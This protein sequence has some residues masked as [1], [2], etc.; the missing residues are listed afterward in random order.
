MMETSRWLLRIPARGQE[1]GGIP[2]VSMELEQQAAITPELLTACKERFAQSPQQR[3]L[4]SAVRKNGISAVAMDLERAQTMQHTFSHVIKGGPVTNQKQSGRCWM[5]AG[6]NVLRIPVMARCNLEEFELS[7][8]Y[9]MFWDK[10]EKANYFLENILETLEEPLDGRLLAWLL[11]APLGDGGQWDMFVN[12]VEKYGVVPKWV[13]PESFHSGQSRAMNALLTAKLRQ[14]AA[15]LR[16]LHAQGEGPSSLRREKERVLGEF[17]GALATFLGEPPQRFDFEYRSRDDEFHREQGLTPVEFFHRYVGMDLR[18]YISVINAPTADK[19]Y[20]RTFTVKYLGNVKGGRDVLYLNADSNVLREAAMA[21]LMDG[22]PVWFGCDVGNMQDRESVI[23]SENLFNYAAVLGVPMQMT[24]AQRLDY[25]E[26][27]MTHAMV[28][29]GVNV[30][31]GS[32]DRWRVENS[33]GAENGNK[34]YF[35]MG[36]DWFDAYMYQVVV[37]RAYLPQDLQA[38]LA[39]PPVELPPWDPMGSLAG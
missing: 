19:P 28:F 6:L 37:R 25:G 16:S 20:G 3:A 22:E 23:L 34:G 33:W 38:A 12:L 1:N 5:F 18:E 26:S 32:P 13:M 21:Q 30:V 14:D 11:S 29:T 31:H 10:F 15:H 36:D 2:K 8:A 35:V 7:Q 39:Q 9:Q 27:L 17:Y 4:A 24:K